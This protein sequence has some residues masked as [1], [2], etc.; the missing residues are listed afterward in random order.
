MGLPSYETRT[1][2]GLAVGLSG[3]R[4]FVLPRDGASLAV[5]ADEKGSHFYRLVSI[6]HGLPG[7]SIPQSLRRH[8][9]EQVMAK[10]SGVVSSIAINPNKASFELGLA[11]RTRYVLY[12]DPPNTHTIPQLEIA[13]RSWMLSLLQWSFNTRK[14]IAVTHNPQ[15]EVSQLEVKV[16]IEPPPSAPINVPIGTPA[17]PIKKDKNK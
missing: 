10:T 2:A 9:K 1:L 12:S 15:M 7:A 16:F 13:S 4:S 11:P 6:H 3:V 17:Q 8:W 14:E 5:A